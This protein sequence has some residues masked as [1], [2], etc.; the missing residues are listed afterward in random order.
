MRPIQQNAI[1]HTLHHT[2]PPIALE[3]LLWLHSHISLL[4]QGIQP[5]RDLW[6]LVRIM[7]EEDAALFTQAAP[8]L[9][10][11]HC[12]PFPPSPLPRPSSV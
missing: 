11:P 2:M 9:E 3:L 10:Q 4:V 8:R 5:G 6:G 1:K 7:N 12:S